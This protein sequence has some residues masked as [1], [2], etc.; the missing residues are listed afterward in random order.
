MFEH[1]QRQ[2]E[3]TAEIIAANCFALHRFAKSA[4]PS[5]RPATISAVDS[6]CGAATQKQNQRHVE[7]PAE[8]NADSPESGQKCRSRG[9][10]RGKE[11]QPEKQKQMQLR[12]TTSVTNPVSFSCFVFNDFGGFWEPLGLIVQKSPKRC[13]Q[14]AGRRPLREAIFDP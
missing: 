2:V 8:M 3:F 13:Q 11:S 1:T 7:F 6:A 9:G 12:D 10:S 4:F 5:R 14:V